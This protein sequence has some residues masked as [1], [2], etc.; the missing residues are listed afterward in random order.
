MLLP[1]VSALAKAKALAP[2][3]LKIEAAFPVSADVEQSKTTRAVRS[4]IRF[5]N[6]SGLTYA[7]PFILIIVDYSI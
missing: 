3:D 6:Y 1:S 5:T 2:C 4:W 7:T